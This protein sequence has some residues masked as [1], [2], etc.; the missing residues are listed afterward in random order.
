MK[1]F[2]GA[3]FMAVTI[4]VALHVVAEEGGTA[5]QNVIGMEKVKS[6]LVTLNELVLSTAATL[7]KVKEASQTPGELKGA[8]SQ[9][10]QEFS[11]LEKQAENI[12]VD[13][14]RMKA[15]SKAHYDQ[16][17]KELDSMGNADLKKKASSRFDEVK[18]QFDKI[19]DSGE[20]AKRAFVPFVSDL[21]DIKTYLQADSTPAAAKSLSNTI[22]KLGL[23]SKTVSG[24]IKDVIEQI[25]RTLAK[26]PSN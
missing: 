22:W 10:T 2:S 15:L 5:T 1:R 6:G 18:E 9:F 25:D 11:S 12:R 13:V 19:M 8:I 24:E 16:W 4:M 20:E 14:V 7:Q 23:K 26:T 17:T 3:L 21:K